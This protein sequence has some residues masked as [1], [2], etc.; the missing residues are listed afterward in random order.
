MGGKTKFKQEILANK[1]AKIFN[2]LK[3][4]KTF[5][6][7]H[8]EVNLYS[9]IP[10]KFLDHYCVNDPHIFKSKKKTQNLEKQFQEIINHTFHKFYVP[11]ILRQAWDF[12]LSK[13]DTTGK[14]NFCYPVSRFT[15]V[16]STQ[17]LETRKIEVDYREW[18]LCVTRGDSLY[19]KF[20][21]HFYTKKETHLFLNCPHQLTIEKAL[22]YAVAKAEGANEGEAF[23]IASSNIS[24]RN[25]TTFSR[26]KYWI[27]VV[28]FFAKNVPPNVSQINDFCDFLESCYEEDNSFF[29]YGSGQTLD[30]LY[31][32]MTDWHYSLNRIKSLGQYFWEGHPIENTQYVRSTMKPEDTVWTFT[33][34][35]SSKELHA[36]GTA[37]R[38]CVVTYKNRC[39]DGHCSIWSLTKTFEDN[40]KR[41]LTIELTNSGNIVQM[42]GIAN[43]AP[44]NEEKAIV[45]QWAKDNFFNISIYY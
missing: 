19:K 36:E 20:T 27:G 32:R 11:P 24:Q 39:I 21:K 29:L 44:K 4:T 40:T 18:Y 10:S 26:K 22:V 9:L 6:T 23:R 31:K 41:S 30:S 33:Q 12:E 45:R 8:K 35:K 3:E 13:K 42:K 5:A 25:Q 43:R 37:Q 28:K 15:E 38:H 1:E 2:R 34:L 14:P 17:P 7:D 16:I